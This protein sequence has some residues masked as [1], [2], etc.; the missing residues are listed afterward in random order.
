MQKLTA[1][2]VQ[3]R[4]SRFRS[5]GKTQIDVQLSQNRK[6]ELEVS[7]YAREKPQM[8]TCLHGFKQKR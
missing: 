7:W 6:S 1:M 4:P 5:Q 2:P 3:I 8:P